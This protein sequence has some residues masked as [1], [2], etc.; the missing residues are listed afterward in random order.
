MS[1]CLFDSI[2]TDN[3]PFFDY[4]C[5]T[6]CQS[7]HIN[8]ILLEA[9]KH[10]FSYTFSFFHWA[11]VDFSLLF[12]LTSLS[13]FSLTGKHLNLLIQ[14]FIRPKHLFAHRY[15]QNHQQA[16]EVSLFA[17]RVILEIIGWEFLKCWS[18]PALMAQKRF[19]KKKQNKTFHQ[20]T[21]PH[22][23]TSILR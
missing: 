3:M 20:K 2:S 14:H 8:L 1:H 23:S 18:L 4:C 17:S 19:K 12:K 9:G 11:N 22:L 15:H 5:P 10:F 16:L 6:C 21:C 7:H 13:Q